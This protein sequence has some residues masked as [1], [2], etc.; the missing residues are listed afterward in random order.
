MQKSV[1]NSV[2][3]AVMASK[4]AYDIYTNFTLNERKEIVEEIKAVLRPLVPKIAQMVY[5]QTCMGN[6]DDK[7]TKLF[8]AIDKTPGVEDLVTEV[9]TGDHGMTLYEQASFG[10]VCATL[11]CT[12]P[13][14]T[15]FASSL[16]S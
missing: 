3:E 5:D 16:P 7:I 11:P 15:L 13:I 14:A 9:N 8:L 2:S 12:N 1:F 10:V 4:G 6:K